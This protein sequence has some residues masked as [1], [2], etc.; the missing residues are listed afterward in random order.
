MKPKKLHLLL[1]A[2]IL[3]NCHI[4]FSQKFFEMMEDENAN[5]YDVQKEANAYFKIHGTGKGT[6]YKQFKRWEADM[7]YYIDEQ[8]N[9]I[10][11]RFIDETTEAFK[12][13]NKSQNQNL[14]TSAYT[15][16]ELGPWNWKN[17]SSWS[18]GLGRL[19]AVRVDGKNQNIIYAGSPQG[20][21]WK[22]TDGGASWIPLTDFIS[23]SALVVY[24]IGMADGSP[25]TVYIGNGSGIFYSYDGGK[26]L[27][28]ISVAGTVRRIEVNPNNHKIILAA[29]TS[30]I[31]KSTNAGQTWASV[32]TGATYDLRFKPGDPNTVYAVGTSFSK[33]TDGGST[34]TAVTMGSTGIK[35]LAVTAANPNYVYVAELGSGAAQNIYRSTDGGATFQTRLTGSTA[36]GTA[37]GGYETTGKDNSSQ[38]S[39]N[40]CFTASPTD[41][42]EVHLGF[43]I[44]WKSTNGGTSF[45]ATTEWTY[46]NSR[47]YTHCDMHCLE[48]VGNTLYTGSDGGIFKS[49]DMGDT[50]TNISQGLGT[51]MFYRLGLSVTDPIL[52][53]CG[54][55]DNGC[56]LMK[57]TGWID[58]VGADGME[59][60]IDP[61]NPNLIYGSCQNGSFYKSTN[62]GTS[63]S[64]ITMPKAGNWTTPFVIDKNSVAYVGLDEVY[65]STNQGSSWTKISSVG[66]AN[67]DFV[68]VAPSDPKYLYLSKGANFWRT[69]DGG[70]TWTPI[71][72]GLSGTINRF[73]VHNSSPT[74]IAVAAGSKVFTSIDGGTTWTDYTGNLPATTNRC[75]VYE[76]GPKEG[77]Y[78]GKNSGVYYRDNTMS[79]WVLYDTG[80]PPVAINELE[81]QYTSGK[82]RAATYGRGIWECDIYTPTGITDNP[83]TKNID[84]NIFPNPTKGIFELSFNSPVEDTYVLEI[85][86]ALGQFVYR[87]IIAK[88]TGH[89]SQKIDLTKYGKGM[90][91][92]SLITS[93][94]QVS[95]EIIIE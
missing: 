59:C 73:S 31:F 11:T 53:A 55:Q 3:I 12:A 14:K 78:V 33:S 50:F 92:V 16:K 56:S 43:I 44:T 46:P 37:Y 45:V 36:N 71:N 19:E 61:A 42:E 93:S 69:S 21:A 77:I 72:A 95:K 75:L 6:L 81:I 62:G 28:N 7:Q 86:N 32:K 22:T 40:F 18:P 4:A 63:Q 80:L 90:Y 66:G 23:S 54:A 5:Y 39:Y 83:A 9:R 29:T 1:L 94:S 34:F 88:Y 10:S 57:S 58:W 91:V 26:T 20:G 35:R 8:G 68:E 52:I 49:T 30:G 13:Q 82:I 27:T 17:T 51:R 47:G 79:G 60:A 25:D 65:K 89:H 64:G 84:M 48:Y 87:D 70:T 24:A 85:R 38:G 15:W 41:P 74:K 67:C 76:N 2:V